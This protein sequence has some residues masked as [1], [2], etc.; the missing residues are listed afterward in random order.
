MKRV[1]GRSPLV[2]LANVSVKCL[3]KSCYRKV[4]TKDF[5][6][7]GENLRQFF[8]TC[9]PPVPG[10]AIHLYFLAAA[11]FAATLSSQSRWWNRAHAIETSPRMTELNPPRTIAIPI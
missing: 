7:K 9:D 4:K 3:L 2:N 1:A 8:R 11:S 5:S 10:R 6:G